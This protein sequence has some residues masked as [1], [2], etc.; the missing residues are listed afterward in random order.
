[1]RREGA[2]GIR[3]RVARGAL[4]LLLAGAVSAGPRSLAWGHANEPAAPSVEQAAP[5]KI[6][7]TQRLGEPVPLD[8]T[9]RDENGNPVSLRAAM[10]GK[11][12]AISFL[13]YQC[14]MLC[15]LI[16]DGLVRSL[17]GM[18]LRPGPDFTILTVSINPK[19]TPDMAA[20]KQGLTLERYGQPDAARGWRFLTGDPAAIRA[21]TEAVGFRYSYDPK[22]DEYDH[23]TGLILL[24]PEGRVARYL[25]GLDIAPRDL[26]L[27]LV[28]A[29]LGRIGSPVDQLLLR[30]YR[31]DHVTGK[32]SLA[33]TNLLRVAGVATV[34]LIG[35]FVL[36]MVR[37]ER[38]AARRSGGSSQAAAN[39]GG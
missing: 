27:G 15:P 11:P 22:T 31:Y 1:M 32:Y 26:R 3:G 7:F 20:A 18:S 24:T 28:E 6:G 8:V 17:Q 14:T 5:V 23:A 4:L 35:T 2:R 30:C 12:T 39:V 9:F 13:Y 33:V 34:L 21:L 16:L 29:G 25:Y 10:D 19:E 38:Q 37:R 36:V